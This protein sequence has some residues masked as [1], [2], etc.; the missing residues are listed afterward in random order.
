MIVLLLRKA[1]QGF[2]GMEVVTWLLRHEPTDA[3][4]RAGNYMKRR[5]EFQGLPI[6]IETEAGGVRRGVNKADGHAW[7]Q[8]LPFAYGYIKG[9]LGVD[10]DDVD[11]FLGLNPDA[12]TAYVVR[13]RRWGAWSKYDE[14]KVM[15]GFNDRMEAERAF[16]LSYSDPRFLGEVDAVPMYCLADL[17]KARR[18]QPL[19][20][21]HLEC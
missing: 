2:D 3:Q 12:E 18:G 9:T 14:D 13:A 21:N 10:G 16:L 19:T 17:L 11:C 4:L 20:R 15:L 8:R 6:A 1:A 5:T 7:E